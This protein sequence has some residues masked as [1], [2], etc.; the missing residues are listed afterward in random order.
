MK[1]EYD[2]FSAAAAYRL[3]L[4]QIVKAATL[5]EARQ[6]AVKALEVQHPRPEPGDISVVGGFGYRTKVPFVVLGISAPTETANPAVQLHTQQARRI[7]LDLI[8]AADAA[9]SDGFLVS[10]LGQKD[11][12][13]SEAQVGQLLEEFRTW[14]DRLRGA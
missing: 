11:L 10:W 1:R 7:G 13:L 6:R 9:D 14:R 2:I 4:D 3:A 5:H 8:E 12:D